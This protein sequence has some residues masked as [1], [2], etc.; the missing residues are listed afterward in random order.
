MVTK[1]SYQETTYD[2][3][4]IVQGSTL[5]LAQ[6]MGN[7]Q[8]IDLIE[9]AGG[10]KEVQGSVSDIVDDENFNRIAHKNATK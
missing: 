2:K 3:R 9:A 1:G 10:L 8:I 4:Q 5:Y 6:K 7:Q